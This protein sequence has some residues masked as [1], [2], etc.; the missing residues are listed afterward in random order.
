[1]MNGSDTVNLWIDRV[2]TGIAPIGTLLL[3]TDGQ[4]LCALD[5]ADYESRL[6][7]LLTKQYPQFNLIDQANPQ[8]FS[9]C[10]RAYLRGDWHSLDEIP[11]NPGG[12][13]FQQQVWLALRT[14]PAGESR[15]YGQLAAQLGKP[16]AARAVGLANS[17][18]PVAIVLPCHRVIG[19]SGQL[20]GYAGGLG[21]KRWL[22]E[23]EASDRQMHLGSA[24]A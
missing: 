24:I 20:T 2:E 5:F 1:M 21:R 13:A 6:Q 11:V 7:Q 23:H 15:S 12:T 3:V 4:S 17:L 8:G 18:N 19:A 14:I 16:G 9:D 22:L 10:L